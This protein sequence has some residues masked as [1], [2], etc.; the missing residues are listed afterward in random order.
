MLSKL[1]QSRIEQQL[2]EIFRH[3]K[4]SQ[5]WVTVEDESSEKASEQSGK[6]AKERRTR[7]VW[8]EQDYYT[9]LIYSYLGCS[10]AFLTE[11]LGRA[12]SKVFSK[13]QKHQKMLALCK[14]TLTV[15]NKPVPIQLLNKTKFF[16][17][18]RYLT[19]M[20]N[21][22]VFVKKEDL[23]QSQKNTIAQFV[24]AFLQQSSHS[25][26]QL[27]EKIIA[28]GLAPTEIEQILL[29]ID[30]EKNIHDR[31]SKNR[32]MLSI[33][34]DEKLRRKGRQQ[35][36]ST[37]E[38]KPYEVQK[39]PKMSTVMPQLKLEM[40]SSEAKEALLEDDSSS[41]NSLLEYYSAPVGELDF[42]YFSDSD[43][44]KR[45][46]STNQ[47]TLK[48]QMSNHT[49]N[50]PLNRAYPE[51][52]AKPTNTFIPIPPPGKQQIPQRCSNMS[53]FAF[54]QPQSHSLQY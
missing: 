46:N 11:I 28:R 8:T 5:I 17:L 34:R 41:S 6:S 30:K 25:E 9:L 52:Q 50:K 10:R 48:R 24:P 31:S 12:S 45:A 40:K 18:I 36:T 22:S 19:T 33:K 54:L 53:L 43:N 37:P 29:C 15:S 32:Q 27:R 35:E 16:Y 2:E 39:R 21:F 47:V 23:N 3:V 14:Q 13:I 38:K 26:K 51:E 44:V 42:K 7:Q 20:Q 1:Q 4:S 49:A